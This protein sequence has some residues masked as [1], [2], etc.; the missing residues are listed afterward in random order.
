MLTSVSMLI[1]I[2][3]PILLALVLFVAPRLRPFIYSV[4]GAVTPFLFAYVSALLATWNSPEVAE[5]WPIEAMWSMSLVPYL[6][7]VALGCGLG[8]LA[9]PAHSTSR[10]LFA[11]VISAVAVTVF[12]MLG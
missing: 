10:Y 4:L 1:E 2:G 9:Q 7:A 6:L 5:R 11:A 12:L 8:M 3:V